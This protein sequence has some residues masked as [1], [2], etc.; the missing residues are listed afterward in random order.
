MFDYQDVT[1]TP[2]SEP[3]SPDNQPELLIERYQS[4]ITASASFILDRF[5]QSEAVVAP[6]SNGFPGDNITVN[7]YTHAS[8]DY[9]S[10]GVSCTYYAAWL[11]AETVISDIF[12]GIDVTFS[13]MPCISCILGVV[14]NSVQ[15]EENWYNEQQLS[16]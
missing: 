13:R 6:G 2:G 15:G 1:Y 3:V 5:L 11:E 10:F 14:A 16:E 4:I 12:T 7:N 9:A 8:Q